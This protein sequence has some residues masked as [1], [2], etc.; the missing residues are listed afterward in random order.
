MGKQKVM[1]KKKAENTSNTIADII[2]FINLDLDDYSTD[3]L[4]DAITLTWF[5][6]SAFTNNT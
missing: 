4:M 2:K 1:F 5:I 3:V 6:C